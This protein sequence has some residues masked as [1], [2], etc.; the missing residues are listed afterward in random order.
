M[1]S[2]QVSVRVNLVDEGEGMKEGVTS[3]TRLGACVNI[4]I[5]V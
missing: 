4:K 3:T 1:L 2:N 5:S